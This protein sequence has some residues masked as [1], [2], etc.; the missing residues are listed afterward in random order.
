M[1]VTDKPITKKQELKLH[2]A[3][4]EICATLEK[5]NAEFMYDG[6]VNVDMYLV[7]K[8]D[9]ETRPTLRVIN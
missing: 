7:V 6:D 5:Y 3:W 4:N 9:D 2:K 8:A 1:E